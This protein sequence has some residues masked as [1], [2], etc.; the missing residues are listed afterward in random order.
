VAR[1]KKL[2]A[3]R[4]PPV[5]KSGFE[6]KIAAYLK[7]NSVKFEYE[8]ER[9]PFLVPVTK[10]SYT[11]DFVLPNGIL[12]EGKGKFDADSR[13]KMEMVIAQHP[14]RDIRMLFMRNNRISKRSDTTYV[15]WCNARGIK[16]AVS[17]LGHVPLEW[18]DE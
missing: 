2:P 6:K 15:A 1:K 18:L 12:I 11:P 13:K 7:A 4:K 16:C 8:P 3:P 5:Y 17:D 9:I 14:D 10:R